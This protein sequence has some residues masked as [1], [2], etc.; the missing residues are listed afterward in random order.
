MNVTVFFNSSAKTKYL[1]FFY[2]LS[3]LLIGQP[4]QQS[5][6]LCKFSFLL[7]LIIMK[8]GLLAE[9]MWS[10]CMSK[11]YRSLCVSFSRTDAGLCIYY[12]FV[13]SNLNVLH[14]SQWITL[15]TQS[16]IV[17]HSYCAIFGIHLLCD[18]SFRLFTISSIHHLQFCCVLSI[19]ALIWLVLPVLFCAAVRRNSV[20]LLSFP[21]LNQV[22]VFSW[23]MLFINR[24]YFI[25]S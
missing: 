2:F 3:V 1:S 18:W 14:D 7:L 12:L 5:L 23:E 19:R 10:V 22:Q 6:Q 4:R 21:F 17:L 20:S 9:I 16:C 8:S 11:S 15:P 25:L 24:Y 13:W